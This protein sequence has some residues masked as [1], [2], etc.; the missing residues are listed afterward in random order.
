MSQPISTP[1]T[2]A[3]ACSCKKPGPDCRRMRRWSRNLNRWIWV[4]KSGRAFLETSDGKPS[5]V[6][7]RGDPDPSVLCP[8]CGAPMARVHGSRNGDFWS[9]F[10]YP[11]CRGTRQIDDVPEAQK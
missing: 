7:L 6:P 5:C 2:P 3:P 4:C 9:C 8:T 11:D 1:P 10:K